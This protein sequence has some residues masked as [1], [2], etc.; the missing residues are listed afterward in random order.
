MMP[1]FYDPAEFVGDNFEDLRRLLIEAGDEVERLPGF[2]PEF[3]AVVADPVLLIAGVRALEPDQCAVRV[4]YDG[5]ARAEVTRL[6]WCLLNSDAAQ[7]DAWP[8]RLPVIPRGAFSTATFFKC[9]IALKLAS[10]IAAF[11]SSVIWRR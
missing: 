3:L 1:L 2:V 5:S 9:S 11:T 10:G 8:L 6:E 4:G 7:V